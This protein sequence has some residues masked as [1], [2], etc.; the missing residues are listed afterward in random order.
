MRRFYTR[1]AFNKLNDTF[2]L[3]L[4]AKTVFQIIFKPLLNRKKIQRVIEKNKNKLNKRKDI[5]NSK[6][7]QKNAKIM[8]CVR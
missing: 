8:N 7:D 3:F 2:S 4:I 1:V 5:F 6:L